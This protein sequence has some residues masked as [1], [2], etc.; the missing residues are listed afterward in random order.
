VVVLGIQLLTVQNWR[1]HS[2]VQWLLIAST[3]VGEV[4]SFL[5]LSMQIYFLRDKVINPPLY[6]MAKPVAGGVDSFSSIS[7]RLSC[8]PF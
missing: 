6:C 3:M 7:A 1:I 2:V 5:V 8:L 4:T